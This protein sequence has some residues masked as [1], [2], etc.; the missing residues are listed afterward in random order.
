MQNYLQTVE[1]QYQQSPTMLRWIEAFNEW[2]DPSN[3]VN[4]WFNNVWNLDTAVGWGLDVWGRIVGVSRNVNVPTFGIYTLSDNSFLNLINA[5]ALAN[6]SDGSIPSL[7]N[8]LMTLFPN[9]GDCYVIDSGGMACTIHLGFTPTKVQV[10]ILKEAFPQPCGVVVT[11]PG[12]STTALSVTIQAGTAASGPFG[13]QVF[14]PNTATGHGGSGS[15]TFAWSETD[16]AAG[17]W[18]IA[19][20]STSVATLSV[21][22]VAN[23]VTSTAN[24]LCT[25]TDT[26]T[27][28]TSTANVNYSLHNTTVAG[29]FTVS[30]QPGTVAATFSNAHTFPPNQVTIVGGV[31]PYTYL[32]RETDDEN[33]V[34]SILGST[35][36][37]ASLSV[38]TNF[39]ASAAD[40]VCIVTDATGA[41][42]TSNTATYSY[43][44][45]PNFGG[46]GFLP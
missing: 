36:P 38:S 15:Y 12:G 43:V 14:S 3:N 28:N 33:A 30:I 35:N 20:G 39:T 10:A 4:V 34:W 24:L 6:I 8:I 42:A 9:K 5:K 23:T 13:A 31:A 1:T 32:W 37:I 11:F 25:I 27:G 17:T 45:I 46:G 19:N 2:L 7:N 41:S 44:Q 16:D 40:L 18:T 22:G 21:S 29:A 26:I